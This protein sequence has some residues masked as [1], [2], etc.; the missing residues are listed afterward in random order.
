[1]TGPWSASA[2]AIAALCELAEESA[3]GG[4]LDDLRRQLETLRVT[5]H[6]E[7]I[8]AAETA[9]LELQRVAES[10]SRLATPEYLDEIGAATRALEQALG[11]WPRSPFVEAMKG[12]SAVVEELQHEVESG[13]K[14]EL[15]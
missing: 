8:E 7:G 11:E 9:A 3:G 2:V 4:R 12:A 5:E 15:R 6:V 13:F 14:G 10:F 1:M